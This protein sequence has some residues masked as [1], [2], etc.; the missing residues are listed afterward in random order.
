MLQRWIWLIATGVLQWWIWL[1][2]TDVLLAG[3]CQPK[4]AR[5]AAAVCCCPLL[6][7]WVWLWVDAR[8]GAILQIMALVPAALACASSAGHAHGACVLS[9]QVLGG[10]V[11]RA[12]ACVVC[13]GAERAQAFQVDRQQR[14]PA[15]SLE[16]PALL[17]GAHILREQAHTGVMGGCECARI[18]SRVSHQEC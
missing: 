5:G 11:E 15:T 3:S 6:R 14:H 13:A 8:A 17:P 7:V 16:W 4:E 2:A 10:R 1:K 12:W 9:V 18:T